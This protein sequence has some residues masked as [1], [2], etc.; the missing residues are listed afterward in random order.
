M[1]GFVLI[2]GRQ[3]LAARI[4]TSEL[5]LDKQTREYTLCSLNQ[6]PVW[7][8]SLKEYLKN[9][10]F[11]LLNLLPSID[12]RHNAS[13]YAINDDLRSLMGAH[14]SFLKTCNNE[15]RRRYIPCSYY[16]EYAEVQQDMEKT[17]NL[18]L[19]ILSLLAEMFLH[20]RP[21]LLPCAR[22][23]YLCHDSAVQ[24]TCTQERKGYSEPADSTTL[25]WLNQRTSWAIE[26]FRACGRAANPK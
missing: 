9:S 25:T 24:S 7:L 11:L 2:N 21:H 23:F 15:I 13:Q 26:Q 19:D 17:S 5:L 18:M 1:L 3:H 16:L 22:D 14:I 20:S 8:N 10:R 4:R 12:I 6:F